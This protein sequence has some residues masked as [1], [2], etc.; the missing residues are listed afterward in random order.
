MIDEAGLR[1]K[2]N[3]FLLSSGAVTFSPAKGSCKIQN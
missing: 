1:I 2:L 3:H